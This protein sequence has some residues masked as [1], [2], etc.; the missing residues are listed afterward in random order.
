MRA[1]HAW[2]WLALVL[3]LA[4]LVL[5]VFACEIC[6]RAQETGKKVNTVSDS[7]EDTATDS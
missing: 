4:F 2:W 7:E 6:D 1:W 3:L 5:S